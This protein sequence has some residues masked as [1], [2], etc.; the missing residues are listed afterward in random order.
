M[1][2]G[3]ARWH[4]NSG[5]WAQRSCSGVT[6]AR[7]STSATLEREGEREWKRSR[8]SSKGATLLSV[9]WLNQPGHRQHTTSMWRTWPNMVI[10]DITSVP[11]FKACRACLIELLHDRVTLDPWRISAGCVNNISRAMQGLQYCFRDHL[12]IYNGL[13]V[14]SSQSR[15]HETGTAFDSKKS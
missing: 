1:A 3:I 6:M 7:C 12:Q 15:V 13:G 11:W 14:T 4:Y 2:R 8:V 5:E 10:H 9:H